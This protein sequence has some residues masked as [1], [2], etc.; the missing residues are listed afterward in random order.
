MDKLF[1]AISITV[2]AATSILQTI[3]DRRFNEEI[4]YLMKQD[5]FILEN[6]L[7]TKQ[8]ILEIKKTINLAENGRGYE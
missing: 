6:Q 4:L 1:I 7:L 3:K 2:L 8:Q 5:K